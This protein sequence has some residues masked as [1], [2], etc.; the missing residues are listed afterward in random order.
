MKIIVLHNRFDNRPIIV[1]PDRISMIQSMEDDGQFS[2]I[3]GQYSNILIESFS[4]DVKESVREIMLKIINA[5]RSD[6]N[7]KR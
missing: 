6:N 7:E 1:R 5:E 4:I 3:V 2:N